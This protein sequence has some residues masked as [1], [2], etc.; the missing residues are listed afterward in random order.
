M[1]RSIYRVPTAHASGVGSFG[2][3]FHQ[4]ALKVLR[5]AG[6]RLECLELASSGAGVLAMRAVVLPL[7]PG[8]LCQAVHCLTQRV[9]ERPVPVVCLVARGPAGFALR[10]LGARLDGRAPSLEALAADEHAVAL[11]FVPTLVHNVLVADCEAR[12]LLPGAFL[13]SG[14]CKELRVLALCAVQLS[15]KALQI[16]G[17]ALV[18]SSE[19]LLERMLRRVQL[20]CIG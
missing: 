5:C 13:V 17:M 6:E 7:A 18:Q 8:P 19:L 1:L 14:S 10:L 11:D 2:T 4:G 3:L 15:V 16:S 20:V 12:G 9:G